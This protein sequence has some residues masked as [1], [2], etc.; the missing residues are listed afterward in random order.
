MP[1]SAPPRRN[2]LLRGH[3]RLHSDIKKY[4]ADDITVKVWIDKIK[5]AKRTGAEITHDLNMFYRQL[6]LQKK[7]GALSIDYQYRR[8][9][10][11]VY[12]TLVR[13][14][15]DFLYIYNRKPILNGENNFIDMMD[16]FHIYIHFFID[17]LKTNNIH[18][19]FFS[20]I[21]HHADYILYLVAKALKIRTTAFFQSIEPGKS[22]MVSD[23]NQL[24]SLS[25]SPED[26]QPV[27]I[28]RSE[29]KSY[30]FME[31]TPK[32]HP[33]IKVLSALLFRRNIDL[34][35]HRITLLRKEKEF[36]RTYRNLITGRLPT[37]KFVYFPLH[38][39][40]ELSTTPLGGK[41]ADQMLAIECLRALLPDDWWIVVKENP[42]Q[43]SYA[44]GALFFA[45]L[46]KIPN[47]AYMGKSFDTYDLTEQSQFCATVTG[48]AGFEA[49]TFGK[50]VLTFGQAVYK[51]FPG[52]TQYR[53]GVVLEDIMS[54]HFSH[55]ELE[56]A[57][58]KLVHGMVDVVVD[59][60][61]IPSIDNFSAEKNT[62]ALASIINQ[63][64]GG[65]HKRATDA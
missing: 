27:P 18:Y 17:L 7:T 10:L 65:P 48:T 32:Y 52:V 42:H 4:L 64:V 58:A 35:F 16:A 25:D 62:R 43:A 30:F 36:K 31:N 29:R 56:L 34:F 22:F 15:T 2:I 54:A 47:V 51:D 6:E 55:A 26:I 1:K 63:V 20:T 50:R 3:G 61:Y 38:L 59:P 14:T 39:Q 11:D 57:Y 9:F 28:K 49:L 21:P 44:R 12:K 24:G 37:G 23:I 13:H 53:D 60:N 40:P 33:Y 5:Y 45:R 41:F 19:V 8:E 46:E